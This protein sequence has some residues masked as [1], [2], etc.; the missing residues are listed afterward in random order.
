MTRRA[1]KGKAHLALGL[2]PR[3]QT[4]LIFSNPLPT[5]QAT[6]EAS[7]IKGHFQG[8]FQGH[9]HH[10]KDLLSYQHPWLCALPFPR[11]SCLRPETGKWMKNGMENTP[12]FSI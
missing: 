9:L 12:G 1:Q 8:H 4:L 11:R 3:L 7:K 5:L 2:G 10:G 6:R